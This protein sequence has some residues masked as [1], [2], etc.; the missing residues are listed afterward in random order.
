MNFNGV[1]N[2]G[3]QVFKGGAVASPRQG[4]RSGSVRFNPG[5]GTQPKVKTYTVTVRG[6]DLVISTPPRKA[7]K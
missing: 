3:R 5:H 7:P 6:G 4:E 2:A 1:N